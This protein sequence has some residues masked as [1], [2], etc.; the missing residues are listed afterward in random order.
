MQQAEVGQSPTLLAHGAAVG[1][2]SILRGYL[3]ALSRESG[4][5][6]GTFAVSWA[7]IWLVLIKLW[8]EG[9]QY[10]VCAVFGCGR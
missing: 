4:P 5:K 1:V 2:S 3:L 8:D 9:H 7:I 10:P 6:K